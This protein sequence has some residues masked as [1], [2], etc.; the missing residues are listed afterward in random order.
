M[1]RFYLFQRVCCLILL[2]TTILTAYADGKG[3]KNES[4]VSN[5]IVVT[6][7]RDN[8]QSNYFDNVLLSENTDICADSVCYFYNQIIEDNLND[9]SRQYIFKDV[10]DNP[11]WKNIIDKIRLDK[12]DKGSVSDLSGLNQNEF[13][14]ALMRAGARCMLVIDSHYL[15]YREK[16]MPMMYHYVNYSL[17]DRNGKKIGSGQTY[18]PAYEP[19]TKKELAKSSR[20]STKKMLAQI[21]KTL[22]Q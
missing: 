17:Y 21:D 12:I 6:G 11:E 1:K 19:Q 3:A 14:N 16:P 9:L 5:S 18:F 4:S 2:M 8:V 13:S 22:N 20:K 10:D 15:D 7:V